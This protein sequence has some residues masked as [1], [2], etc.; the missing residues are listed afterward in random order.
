MNAITAQLNVKGYSI[1][2]EVTVQI[3]YIEDG[4]FILEECNHAGAETQEFTDWTGYG[5]HITEH[6]A[7][8]LECDKANCKA[9]NLYGEW[10]LR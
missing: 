7:Y 6:T 1:A 2:E 10:E 9:V 8:G 5:E 3:G 4:E